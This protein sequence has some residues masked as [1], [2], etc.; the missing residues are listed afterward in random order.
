MLPEPARQTIEQHVRAIHLFLRNGLPDPALALIHVGMDAFGALGRLL[1]QKRTGRQDFVTRA[2][3]YMLKPKQFPVTAL[4]LYGARCGLLHTLGP[5][6]DLSA[7]G[8]VRQIIYARG[9]RE[10]GPANAVIAEVCKLSPQ[11]PAVVVVKIDNIADAF[12][13]G[14]ASFGKDVDAATPEF[15]DEVGTRARKL[16]GQFGEFPGFQGVEGSEDV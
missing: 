7:V 12:V 11:L 6:S 10:P 8:R 1:G 5:E 3:R 15:R 14:I 4:K 13:A 2:D 16:F 9:H